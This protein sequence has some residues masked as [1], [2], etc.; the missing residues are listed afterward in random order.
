MNNFQQLQEQEENRFLT[1][2][3]NQIRENLSA[4]FSSF[5]FVGDVVDVYLPKVLEMFVVIL[6]G[7]E[8]VVKQA[9]GPE[10]GGEHGRG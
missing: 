4:T 5:R 7:D 8:D 1:Q 9:R 3:K 2:D 6:G 10:S